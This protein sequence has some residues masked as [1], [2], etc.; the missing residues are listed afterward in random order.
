MIEAD[1]VVI[2][3]DDN[4]DMFCRWCANGGNLYCCS[5]CSNTFCSKCIKRNFD[6][7]TIKRIEAE[8]SWKCFVCDPKDLY[9]LRSI[10]R[11]LTTH[12]DTLKR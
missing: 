8:D 9:P 6:P 3:G 7:Q 5:Y 1:M 11:A 2:S 10:S 4:T 12:I